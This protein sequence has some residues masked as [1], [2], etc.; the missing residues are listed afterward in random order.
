MNEVVIK[1]H[2]CQYCPCATLKFDRGSEQ[3][4]MYCQTKH[5]LIMLRKDWGSHDI[6]DWCPFLASKQKQKYK[7]HLKEK[8]K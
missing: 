1:I 8:Y 3:D 2:D 5:S 7:L 4:I 6:P